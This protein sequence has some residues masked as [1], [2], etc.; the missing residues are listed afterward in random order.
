MRRARAMAHDGLRPRH[1]SHQV[2]NGC[3]TRHRKCLGGSRRRMRRA[4]YKGREGQAMTWRTKATAQGGGGRASNTGT[5]DDT[6][7]ST[8]PSQCLRRRYESPES[9]T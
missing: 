7:A 4:P 8:P 5:N 9:L 6:G 2:S 3:P 1:W